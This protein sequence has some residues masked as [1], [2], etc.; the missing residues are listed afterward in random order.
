MHDIQTLIERLKENEIIVQKFHE[1][2][3]RFLS[4]LNFR[5]F[6]EV[7]ISEIIEKFSVH[8][9]WISIA[10][11]SD[12]ASFL[13][14]IRNSEILH[15]RINVVDESEFGKIAGKLTKPLLANRN[16]DRFF[17]LNPPPDIRSMAIAPLTLD[18]KLIGT[19]NQ[20]DMSEDRFC[21]GKDTSLLER[22]AVKVSLCL[23]NVTAHEKLKFLAYH[24]PLT[25]LLNRRVMENV[26]E[27]EFCRA[28]RYFSALS[29]V[30]ID[31]DNFKEVNDRYGH[32]VG[33]ELLKHVAGIFSAMT[34]RSDV[35][36]RFAGDEFVFLLPET[37]LMRARAFMVRVVMRVQDIPFR[38]SEGNQIRTSFSYGIASSDEK[39][40]DDYSTL[41][42][43]ADERLLIEKKDRGSIEKILKIIKS[44]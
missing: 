24:D 29:V 2:E 28:K 20:A 12:I 31:L 4:I 8:Y 33:D 1:V 9:V 16:L 34:R 40:M 44:A 21:P 37:Q 19:L 3:S 42:K 41:I 13:D 5:D 25:G 43:K 10:D 27:R 22:L 30:F 39:G 14:S 38:D 7:L 36:A 17:V 6:F 32:D 26:L 18:G 15:D 35:V 11:S 23:S